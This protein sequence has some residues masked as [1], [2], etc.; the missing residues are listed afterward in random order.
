MVIIGDCNI[1]CVSF[2]FAVSN[3]LFAMHCTIKFIIY[4]RLS[5]CENSVDP[6]ERFS[7]NTTVECIGRDGGT[8]A[9]DDG[10]CKTDARDGDEDA[11]KFDAGTEKWYDEDT[12]VDLCDVEGTE[13]YSRDDSVDRNEMSSEASAQMLSHKNFLEEAERAD[14]DMELSNFAFNYQK[15]V[16]VTKKKE[17]S[18]TKKKEVS[19]SKNQSKQKKKPTRM[20]FGLSR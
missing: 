4:H 15:E 10:E 19:S 5:S 1:Y 9:R 17:V 20:S 12:S 3:V 6:D 2:V 13:S 16:S 11:S 14:S 7:Q 8:I 18:L